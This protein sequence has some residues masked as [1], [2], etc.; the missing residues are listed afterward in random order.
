MRNHARFV[1]S[2]AILALLLI[3]AHVRGQDS[4]YELPSEP[5]VEGQDSFESFAEAVLAEE[6]IFEPT[7]DITAEGFVGSVPRT[8]WSA[9]A[10]LVAFRPDFRNVDFSE[11]GDDIYFVTPRLF[12]GWESESG[13]G[14]RGRLWGFEAEGSETNYSLPGGFSTMRGFNFRGGLLAPSTT[15]D[16]F[17]LRAGSLDIDFYKRFGAG[18]T[19]LVLGAGIK[20]AAIQ[21][22]RP[23]FSEDIIAGAG[24]GLLGELRHVFYQ[25]DHS[26]VALVG[27][28]RVGFLIGESRN[29]TTPTSV[30]ISPSVI[31]LPS[32]L[33][34]LPPTIQQ[35]SSTSITERH[36]DMTLSEAA[37]GLEWKRDL[38][39]SVLT[40]RGQYE[41]QFWNTDGS[42]DLSFN[43]GVVRAGLSW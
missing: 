25:N 23:A 15:A 36:T 3:S 26:E 34:S 41:A 12:V 4:I 2:V 21:Y 22:E 43:G 28:G 18:Q 27:S 1:T 7:I 30:S 35:Q 6:R 19:S 10:E 29:E 37:L 11:D 33:L 39:W 20:S 38:G 8:A 5:T 9:G 40:M 17:K 42:N 13:F 16:P 24:V 14:F 32:T 31:S